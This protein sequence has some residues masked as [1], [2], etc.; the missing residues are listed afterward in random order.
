MSQ[1]RLVLVV[2][3]SGAGKDSLIAGARLA[4]SDDPRVV[5]PRRLV[6]RAANAAEDHATLSPEEFGRGLAAGSFPLHWQAHGLSYALPSSVRDDLE[7]GRAV[8]ANVSRAVLADARSRFPA[9]TVVEI[10][11]PVALRAERLA[12]R[13]RESR[14]DIAARLARQPAAA[15]DPDAIIVNDGLLDDGIAR[16]VA[17]IRRSGPILARNSR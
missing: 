14:E 7:A 6:T 3:P 1:G 16:L 8:V 12:G 13:G 9:V 17:I 2:G 4:L 11:A 10:T 5:F 15:V